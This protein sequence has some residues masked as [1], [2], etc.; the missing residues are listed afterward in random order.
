MFVTLLL[1]YIFLFEWTIFDIHLISPIV[2]AL[3]MSIPVL[4]FFLVFFSG[5]SFYLFRPFIR[6]LVLLLLFLAWAFLPSFLSTHAPEC[7]SQ[8]SKYLLRYLMIFSVGTYFMSRF[9]AQILT[10]KLFSIIGLLVL[11][12]FLC[13]NIDFYSYPYLKPFAFSGNGAPIYGPLGLF[14]TPLNV[15]HYEML[16]LIGYWIEPSKASGFLFPAFFLGQAIYFYNFKRIWKYISYACLLGGFLCLSN[17]GY[18]GFA[19]AVLFGIL[20]VMRFPKIKLLHL[21]G[22]ALGIGFIVFAL[23]GRLY[24]VNHSINSDFLRVASGASFKD[25]SL[26]YDEISGGRVQLFQSNLNTLLK[27]PIG[28]GMRIPGTNEDGEGFNITAGAPGFWLT[29]TGMPGLLLLLLVQL[30]TLYTNIK[31]NISIFELRLTQAWIT[32]LLQ[33]SVYG[34]WMSPFFH[35]LAVLFFIAVFHDQLAKYR[36]SQ[37]IEV[38]SVGL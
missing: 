34:D 13:L 2:N 15:S 29:F 28:I 24:I 32:A 36:Y 38:K 25:T 27:N 21:V 6:Y 17:A 1:I 11:L 16:R 5:S 30:Q 7:V 9:S 14:A 10:I 26:N 37:L 23:F 20:R 3:K 31:S 8:W 35:T 19:G 4:L 22:L 18:L 12:Q 33:Q